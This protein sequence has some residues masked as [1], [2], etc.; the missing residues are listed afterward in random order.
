MGGPG[1]AKEE[2]N[3]TKQENSFTKS[4]ERN[5]RIGEGKSIGRHCCQIRIL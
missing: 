1:E 2:G 3:Y 5:L 4:I